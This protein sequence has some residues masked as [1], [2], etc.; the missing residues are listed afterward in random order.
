MYKKN[1]P[2]PC[3]DSLCTLC[4]NIVT[5]KKRCKFRTNKFK[6]ILKF[7]MKKTVSQSNEGAQ[8]YQKCSY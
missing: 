5:D 7:K 4:S 6:L 8:N 2:L 3:L 1:I